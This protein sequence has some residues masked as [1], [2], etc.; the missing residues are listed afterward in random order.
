MALLEIACFNLDS[1]ITAIESGADRV[2]LCDNADLGGTTPQD[3][4]RW[5]SEIRSRT[6]TNRSNPD[7]LLLPP[8][9]VM[10]RPRGGTFIYTDKEYEEMKKTIISLK[11]SGL[12]DGFVF[13]ILLLLKTSDDGGGTTT[14]SSSI[15]VA[16]D[17]DRTKKLV[18]LA[19]PLPCTFHRA[20]DEVENLSRALEDVI[21]CGITTVLTSGGTVNAVQGA[22]V[23]GQLVQE[24]AG[25][26]TV[27]PGGGVRSTNL[28]MLHQTINSSA[29][30][31]SALI[32]PESVVTDKE[33]ILRMLEILR[34]EAT[35]TTTD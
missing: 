10:V 18:E 3:V 2:E 7:G 22:E 20:F 29:Y 33:E 25:R 24:A 31:S 19:H 12:V 30:H 26:I 16:I 35:T 1:A 13:G 8:I 17:I 4:M 5:I 27:M 11:T 15:E 34:P 23:L 28:K 9:N 14:A 32:A 6:L 21:S